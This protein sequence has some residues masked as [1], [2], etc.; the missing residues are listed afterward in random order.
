MAVVMYASI[1]K[2]GLAISV[3]LLIPL[4]IEA[5]LASP[6]THDEIHPITNFTAYVDSPNGW[7]P[8]TVEVWP[9]DTL[10]GIIGEFL[11][12]WEHINI[13][14]AGMQVHIIYK[15]IFGGKC[16]STYWHEYTH[17]WLDY[18]SEFI[19]SEEED[20]VWMTEHCNCC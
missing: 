17:A 4:T 19:M 2:A 13:E 8:V 9:D 16:H 10:P 6:N 18:N 20:H 12:R 3:V 11:P 15:E 5:A 1:M 14:E 7:Y